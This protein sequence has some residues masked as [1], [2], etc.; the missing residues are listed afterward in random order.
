[1]CY[2]EDGR[3]RREEDRRHWYSPLY[4][5]CCFSVYTCVCVCL[6]LCGALLDLVWCDIKKRGEERQTEV[7]CKVKPKKLSPQGMRVSG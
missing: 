3:G 5:T 2:E 6:H 7:S 1:M 4:C